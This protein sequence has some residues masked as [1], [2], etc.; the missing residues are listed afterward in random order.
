MYSLA[1]APPVRGFPP[2]GLSI[3]ED[4]PPPPLIW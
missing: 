2:G 4:A 1:W 3:L